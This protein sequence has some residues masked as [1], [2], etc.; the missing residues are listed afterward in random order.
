[1]LNLTRNYSVSFPAG[2]QSGH[3]KVLGEPTYGALITKTHMFISGNFS[4]I[5]A[6]LYKYF[7]G[8]VSSG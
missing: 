8:Q 5:I 4:K 3:G 2:R 1:M 7:S 6:F